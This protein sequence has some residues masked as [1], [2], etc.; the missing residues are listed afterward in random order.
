VPRMFFFFSCPRLSLCEEKIRFW[1][2]WGANRSFCIENMMSR[3]FSVV[4]FR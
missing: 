2:N 4:P 3:L 1:A